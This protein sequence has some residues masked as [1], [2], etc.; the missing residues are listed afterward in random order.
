[1]PV[2]WRAIQRVDELNLNRHLRK[3]VGGHSFE[4]TPAGLEA[5]QEHF[6]PNGNM[7]KKIQLPNGLSWH[8][9]SFMMASE[10]VEHWNLE[11]YL[12][13]E[14]FYKED[15]AWHNVASTKQSS[16]AMSAPIPS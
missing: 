3:T 11:E 14:G 6:G 9:R 1:M 15:G 2:T 13:S 10:I 5:L 16:S 4:L 8:G 12:D 7:G